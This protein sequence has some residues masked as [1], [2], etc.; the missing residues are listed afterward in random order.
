VGQVTGA[1]VRLSPEDVVEVLAERT[2]DSAE[3][4]EGGTEDSGHIIIRCGSLTLYA[5]AP[6][7]YDDA[8]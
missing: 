2:I 5:D 3:F 1:R 8:A 7:L 4:V 6:A